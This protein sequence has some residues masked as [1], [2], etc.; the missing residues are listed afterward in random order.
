MP[1][2]RFRAAA[3]SCP[4]G[5]LRAMFCSLLHSSVAASKEGGSTHLH[6]FYFL[7]VL[8]RLIMREART[9]FS[10]SPTLVRV[11]HGGKS[12]FRFSVLV[13]LCRKGGYNKGK[14]QGQPIR[15]GKSILQG[16]STRA[17]PAPSNKGSSSLDAP[18]GLPGSRLASIHQ[19]VS[20]PGSSTHP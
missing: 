14:S 16:I 11:S 3:F 17:A 20:E 9:S 8:F 1:S 12:P 10:S 7:L 6:L 2:F 5:S 4:W 18:N 13:R 19:V 15:F